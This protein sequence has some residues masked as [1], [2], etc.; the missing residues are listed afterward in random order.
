[1]ENLIYFFKCLLEEQF[2]NVRVFA[3]SM[4]SVFDILP[5]I[6]KKKFPE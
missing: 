2:S 4:I 3:H 6:V 1:M 5:I